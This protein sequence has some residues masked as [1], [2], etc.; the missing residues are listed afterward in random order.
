MTWYADL[1]PIDCFPFSD[2]RSLR[3]VG[4]LDA[5]HTFETGPI[6]SED[7]ERLC[8]L[9]VSPWQPVVAA[10]VHGCELCRHTSGPSL[11]RY[12]DVE[13]PLGV[14]NVFVPAEGVIYVAPSL[15]VHY[16][17]AHQY[18]PPDELLVAVRACPPTTSMEYKRALLAAGGR[19]LLHSEGRS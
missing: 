11:L 5:L 14:A 4:W 3:A 13:V 17:D 6:S 16:I 19:G 7:F 18:R 12:R 2:A 9:L 8:R 10:G 1:G 15:I